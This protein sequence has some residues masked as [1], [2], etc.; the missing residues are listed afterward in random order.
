MQPAQGYSSYEEHSFWEKWYRRHL[1]VELTLA[2]L[3]FRD[4]N[5]CS[6][7]GYT[8]EQAYERGIRMVGRTV[9]EYCVD[10]QAQL[11]ATD[12][13]HY[14]ERQ[15]MSGPV[16]VVDLFAGSGNLLY[17]IAGR[18]RAEYGFGMEA[19]PV[20]AGLTMRN[21]GIVASP[22]QVINASW[23]NFDPS[24]LTEAQT[25]VMIIDPPWGHGHT[26]QG[27][28]LRATEPPVPDVLAALIPKLHHST[29]WVIKTFEDTVPASLSV[30]TDQM[31][32]HHYRTLNTMA[33]GTNVGYLIGTTRGRV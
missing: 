29:V 9:I 22:W 11:I 30:I 1:Q 23:N 21:L 28:D 31:V 33:P 19:D 3:H 6:I 32:H 4:R 20:V 24:I 15:G 8:P 26:S 17:H 5:A 25:I 16:A 14:L 18:L 7:Y 10:S 2:D 13:L 12:V 27:L